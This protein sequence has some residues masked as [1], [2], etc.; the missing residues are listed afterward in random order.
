MLWSSIPKRKGY[1]KSINR[2]RTFYKILTFCSLQLT[3]IALKFLL[4]VTLNQIW[5]ENCY[6]KCLSRNFVISFWFLQKKVGLRRQKTQTIISSFVI[7]HYNQLLH[8]KLKRCLNVTRSCVLVS[9]TNLPKV[10]IHHYYHGVIFI[11]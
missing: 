1:T 6:C 4:M 10:L 9:A 2:L 5:F 8:P 11:W 3:V 7:L